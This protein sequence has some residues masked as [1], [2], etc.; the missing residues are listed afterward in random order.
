MHYVSSMKL[1]ERIGAGA[2]ATVSMV[3]VEGIPCIAKQPR[4]ELLTE[5]DNQSQEICRSFANECSVLARLRHPNIVQYMGVHCGADPLNL[6][7][8]MEHMP[9][10]LEIALDICRMKFPLSL[11]LSVLL[12]ISLGMLY[13]HLNGVIH[14]DLTADNVLLSPA[15]DAK[16]A[17][18]GCSKILN[19]DG[20]TELPQTRL[21]GA[22]A[23]MP[24]EAL[25]GNTAYSE[26]LDVFSFGALSL[27]VA[28][29]S[30]PERYMGENVSPKA[31]EVQE[32]EIERRQKTFAKL[33]HKHCLVT[34]IRKCLSDKELNRPSSRAINQ[35]M[36]FWAQKQPKRLED[37]LLVYEKLH[38]KLM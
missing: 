24:P 1:I 13:I 12:N 36:R 30:F 18:F 37:V 4:K 5:N 28:T 15:L 19:S 17:D 2:N 33:D 35:T 11:Q 20:R 38:D 6:T 8:I 21:P 16:I 10:N 31:K 32:V 7:M 34:L 23:Y 9:T 29:Q 25:K 14:C 22:L 3:E 26:K 27:F